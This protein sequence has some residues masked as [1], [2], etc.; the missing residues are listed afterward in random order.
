[1]IFHCE[2]RQYGG[3]SVF[4]YNVFWFGFTVIILKKMQSQQVY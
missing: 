4:S 1:L 3:H 2:N